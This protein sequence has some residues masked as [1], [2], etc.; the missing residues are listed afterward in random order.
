MG[1][2]MRKHKRLFAAIIAGAL[3]LVMILSVVLPFV[4]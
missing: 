1:N 4:F 3:A 2:K